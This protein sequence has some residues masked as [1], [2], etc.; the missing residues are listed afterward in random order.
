MTGTSLGVSYDPYIPVKTVEK[1]VTREVPMNILDK[2]IKQI[3]IEVKQPIY[4]FKYDTSSGAENVMD[5]NAAKVDISTV[6]E[7]IHANKIKIDNILTI[8]L[9]IVNT[10]GITCGTI[11]LNSDILNDARFDAICVSTYSN[12]YRFYFF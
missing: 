3:N 9:C 2:F 5:T 8:Q 10:D 4:L 1:I 6:K 11:T 12:L 7:F